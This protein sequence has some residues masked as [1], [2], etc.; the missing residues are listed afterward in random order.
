MVSSAVQ[1]FYM[2]MQV[3]LSDFHFPA[4][5][6]DVWQRKA[7]SHC[8][9]SPFKSEFCCWK[10]FL[11]LWLQAPPQLSVPLSSCRTVSGG[12]GEL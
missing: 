4:S 10:I 6:C 1:M 9:K 8:T 11:K 12:S 5:G 7:S 3:D 2:F